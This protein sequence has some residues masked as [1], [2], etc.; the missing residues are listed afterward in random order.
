M[1]RPD[2]PPLP[3]YDDSSRLWHYH[4]LCRHCTPT[5]ITSGYVLPTRGEAVEIRDDLNASILAPVHHYIVTGCG[6][7]A[8]VR[9]CTPPIITAG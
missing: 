7:L 1:S 4:V 6:L 8:C 9:R 2:R 5:G 3:R